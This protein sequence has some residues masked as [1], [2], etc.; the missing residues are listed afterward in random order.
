[1]TDNVTETS[2]TTET[3]TIDP[4]EYAAARKQVEDLTAELERF[5]GKH[6]EAEKARKAEEAARRKAAEEAARKSGDLESLEKSWMEKFSA[7]EAELS[8]ELERQ[9]GII[10]ALTVGATSINLAA[11][12]AMDGCA[13]G[14]EPHI[15]ARLQ[16]EWVD[17]HPQVR[18]LGKDGRPSA[19]TLQDLEK[20]LK[21]VAYLAPLIKGSQ[22]TGSGHKGAGGVTGGPPVMTRKAFDE[23][24]P[25]ARADFIQRQKGRLVD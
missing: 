10:H 19:M 9:S 11:K 12:L 6:A 20:E 8:T 16:T 7:R 22:A 23:L 15:R 13:E 5:R 14:L 3:I 4:V 24:E 2:E 25:V 18:V 1:M 21:T 17:G